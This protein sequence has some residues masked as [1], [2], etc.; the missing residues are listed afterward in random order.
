MQILNRDKWFL[1]PVFLFGFSVV[2]MA[3]FLFLCIYW[4]IEVNAVLEA[5][6]DKFNL[7]PLQFME[8]QAG[9]IIM[10]LSLLMGIIMTGILMIFSYSQKTFQLYRLQNNFISSF[11]HELKTPV[12]SLKLYL[13]TFLKYNLS[14][15]ERR[16][17]LKYM[18]QDVTRLSDN[19]SSIL[20]LARI[21]SKNYQGEFEIA[22][23][24]ERVKT[25]YKEGGH[26]FENCDINIENNLEHE[27]YYPINSLLF[28]MLLM[29]LATNAVKY[30]RSEKPK[31]TISFVLQRKDLYI[32][33]IDNG[34]GINKHE[35]RKIFRKFYQIGHADDMSAKGS[36]L[37]LY[38]VKNIVRIHNWKIKAASRKNKNGAIFTLILPQEGRKIGNKN[39][40]WEN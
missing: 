7:D 37:G 26:L 20:N 10:V 18:I 28:E 13:E 31:L 40:V 11:T 4:Y 27:F 9:V 19:I 29:N 34:I 38:M 16:K 36:G 5:V 12:T 25:I 30:N 32:N 33:F 17:Y 1:H 24:V 14:V 21:E 35:V 2:A 3:T 39:I 8:Y 15:E 23:L 22:G 6:I